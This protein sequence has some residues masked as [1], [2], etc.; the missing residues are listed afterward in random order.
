M[1]PGIAILLS[2]SMLALL[3]AFLFATRG[4]GAREP[5]GSGGYWDEGVE[6][7]VRAQVSNTYVDELGPVRSRE[8]FYRAMDAFVKLDR[9]CD[10]I[11]PEEHRRWK[12]DT[13]GRYG[14]LGVK[15]NNVDEGLQVMGVLPGGPADLAG[16][17]VGDTIVSAS[18]RRLGGLDVEMIT[19]LLK[20]KPG[21]AVTVRTVR[22]PRPEQGP[23]TG[24]EVEVVV[25]RGVIRPPT[26][27]TRRLGKEGEF[28]QVRLTDFT[29]E[30]AQDFD[31][32]MNRLQTTEPVKGVILDLRHNGGG[33]LGVAV[34]VADRFLRSGRLIVR[35]E[36]RGVDATR[37]YVSRDSKGKILDLPL[38]VL[39]DKWSA[40]ASEVVAGALQDHR[41]GVLVGART[42]GKFLVQSITEIPRRDA[43]VKL[44]TSRY[45]TPSGRSYQG[46]SDEA[47]RREPR[48]E[49]SGLVPDVVI[50]L[51]KE[52]GDKLAQFWRD[53]EGK[54]WNEE[55]LHPEIPDDF[56]DPQL[57]RALLLLRGDVVFQKIPLGQKPS[58]RNG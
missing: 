21:S 33:V 7:F 42:Y 58:R 54:P 43:A 3:M 31:A 29:E 9:Y 50:R 17:K 47:T 11:P 22:G 51:S 5:R 6:A 40:S 48:A 39:V 34:R 55:K 38:I 8:S 41:R 14:G 44:T 20:G 18:G 15:I 46:A 28:L 35:M 2:T 10:F 32:V 12:E 37:N 27:F 30:T 23:L 4:A 16:I 1:R 53:E 52:E 24:P 25:K 26:V 49:G 13:A 56:A 45:Y 19:E 36:G 57:V